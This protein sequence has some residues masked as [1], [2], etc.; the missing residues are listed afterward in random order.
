MFSALVGN[1]S[2]I[3]PQKLCSNYPSLNILSLHSSSFTAVPFDGVKEDYGQT[4]SRE[5]LAN[6]GSPRWMT[7]KSVC[8]CSKALKW[9]S[10]YQ[11]SNSV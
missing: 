8:V 5:K 6:T 7:I 1:R 2:G 9:S 11:G 10:H 3:Q 4:Y